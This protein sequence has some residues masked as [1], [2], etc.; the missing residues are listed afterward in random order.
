MVSKSGPTE[1]DVALMD[2]Q[3]QADETALMWALAAVPRGVN[4]GLQQAQGSTAA[5]TGAMGDIR[6]QFRMDITDL[7]NTQMLKQLDTDMMQVM[8]AS[9]SGNW[10]YG[11]M[12][13]ALTKYQTDVAIDKDMRRNVTV[14][15][16][17]DVMNESAM[18]KS[19]ITEQPITVRSAEEKPK[20]AEATH[21]GTGKKPAHRRPGF[22]LFS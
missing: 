6:E 21:E 2:R 5:Y 15:G 20:A 11:N 4:Q 13:A 10:A 16:R 18:G 14:D 1:K 22:N 9:K 3:V 17:T 8:D 19:L 7:P 12:A